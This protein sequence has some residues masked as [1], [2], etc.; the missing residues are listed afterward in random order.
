MTW[1]SDRDYGEQFM[2]QAIALCDA[3]YLRKYGLFKRAS[4]ERDVKQA[5]DLEI[6][7]FKGG[8]SL[9]VR[10]RRPEFFGWNDFTIRY[11]RDSGAETEYSKIMRGLM[12]WFFYGWT[13]RKQELARW[14][15][16]DMDVF[17][18]HVAEHGFHALL[19]DGTF[20]VRANPNDG[21]YLLG[22]LPNRFDPALIVARSDPPARPLPRPSLSLSEL[23]RTCGVILAWPL[24]VGVIYADG[25]A[26]CLACLD[27]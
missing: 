18:A 27:G 16:L 15:L 10:I 19:S 24:A 12:D 25:T 13:N 9:G 21:T 1:E 22:C 7:M 3:I 6:T 4:Y 2:E 20:E 17:R 26:E 14:L 8:N 5:T 23:C 11:K